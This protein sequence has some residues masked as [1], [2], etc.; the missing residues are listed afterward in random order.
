MNQQT[1]LERLKSFEGF[2]PYMYRCTGGAVTAGIGHALATAADAAVLQW[3]ISGRPASP[4]E[5]AGDFE[6][7]AA[8]P[9]GLVAEHYEP[10]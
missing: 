8:A 4:V 3:E 6:K 5:I 2:V 1:I 10:L 7:I 9:I